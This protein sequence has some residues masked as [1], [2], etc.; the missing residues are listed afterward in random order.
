MNISFT[1]PSVTISPML[2]LLHFVMSSITITFSNAH[3]L[4]LRSWRW[5]LTLRALKSLGRSFNDSTAR[6]WADAANDIKRNSIVSFSLFIFFIII[7]FSDAMINSQDALRLPCNP[8]RPFP[9]L[10]YTNKQLCLY[11]FPH[12]YRFRSIGLHSTLPNLY[13]VLQPYDTI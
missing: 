7:E 1:G 4:P 9:H 13:P 3:G 6:R 11:S 8:H 12:L 5:F 2:P 10:F